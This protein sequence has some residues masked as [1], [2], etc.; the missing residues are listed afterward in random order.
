MRLINYVMAV[1]CVGINNAEELKAVRLLQV[2]D[3]FPART[4][5]FGCFLSCFICRTFFE[6]HP[7]N[8]FSIVY[9]NQLLKHAN[10]YN[11]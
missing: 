6:V 10:I 5:L 9:R 4:K 11:P 8:P 3:D 1:L 2:G 7:Y